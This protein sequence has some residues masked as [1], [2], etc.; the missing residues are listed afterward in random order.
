[1]DVEVDQGRNGE[2]QVGV[3]KGGKKTAIR[4]HD[5]RLDFRM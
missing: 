5:Q 4:L 3:S 2:I 1:M